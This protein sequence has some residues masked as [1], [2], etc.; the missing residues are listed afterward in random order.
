MKKLVTVNNKPDPAQFLKFLRNISGLSLREARELNDY[1]LESI[2][3]PL[4]AGITEE[5]A[6]ELIKILSNLGI[7]NVLKVEDTDINS[8]MFLCPNDNDDYEFGFLSEN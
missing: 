6:N 3:C 8:P 2:P 7:E 1:I 4:F 5:K